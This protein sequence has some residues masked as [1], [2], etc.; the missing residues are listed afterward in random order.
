MDKSTFKGTIISIQ[1]RIRL[2]RSFDESSYTLEGQVV[3]IADE[4]AQI[5][6][7]MDDFLRYHVL[8]IG[9][10]LDHDIFD[11]IRDFYLNK[12]ELN[13]DNLIDVE[14][15]RKKEITIRCLVDYLVTTLIN[16][17]EK[18]LDNNLEAFK[19]RRRIVSFGSKKKLINDFHKYINNKCF[20]EYKVKEMD[21]RGR[22]VVESLY[23]YYKKDPRRLP[24]STQ[25]KYKKRGITT[26]VDYISGMTDRYAIEKYNEMI[27]IGSFLFSVGIE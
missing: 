16:E 14:D 18:E 10:F 4:I 19:I 8:T 12:Y 11:D 9:Q 1:P 5:T 15:N 7:D 6:H 13:F 2:T 25:I 27:E 3:A 23:N 22:D 17:T 26:I 24:E 21:R 20:S